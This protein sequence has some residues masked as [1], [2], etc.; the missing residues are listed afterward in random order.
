MF[1]SSKLAKERVKVKIFNKESQMYESMT[2]NFFLV[3]NLDFLK[4]KTDFLIY[5]TTSIF[6]ILYY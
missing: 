3:K 2:T 1:T 6:I 4:L 5:R